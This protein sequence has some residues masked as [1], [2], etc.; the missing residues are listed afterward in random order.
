M[1]ASATFSTHDLY[2]ASALKIFKFRL[3]DVKKEL[4]GKGLFIFEDRPERVNLVREYFSGDL[5]GSLKAFA[6][7]W[8]DL[9]NLVN[10]VE[11]SRPNDPVVMHKR[12]ADVAIEAK[13]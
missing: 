9:R 6:N 12:R 13:K 5:Q 2:L 10:E 8:S 11:V 1:N 7:A 3:L 4:T